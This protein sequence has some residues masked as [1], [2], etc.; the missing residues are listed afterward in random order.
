MDNPETLPLGQAA[1]YAAILFL[2]LATASGI[3][4]VLLA[5]MGKL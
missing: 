1:A 5:S 3:V 2:S 4:A